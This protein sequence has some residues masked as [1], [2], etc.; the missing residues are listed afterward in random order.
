MT[1]WWVASYVVLWVAVVLMAA[2]LLGTMREVAVLRRG[3]T[4]P[5]RQRQRSDPNGP[6]LGT[7]L[8][9][10]TLETANGFGP[11]PLRE[12]D[13]KMVLLA[14]LTPTCE[15]C[16]LAVESLNALADAARDRLDVRVIL[17]GPETAA[18]SFLKLFPLHA[19]VVLDHNYA[20]SGDFGVHITPSGLLYDENGL[21]LRTGTISEPEE[22]AALVEGDTTGA[23]A[24]PP[25][26]NGA[27]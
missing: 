10:L 16:Q 26:S 24:V 8:P 27:D 15:G 23:L 7:P 25:T 22:L 6:D 9:D 17:S 14:F 18:R 13:R 20:L 2:L 21:L 19:P 5:R 1:G 3:R 11:V 12:R 4:A